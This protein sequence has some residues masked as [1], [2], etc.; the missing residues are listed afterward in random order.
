MAFNNKHVPATANGLETNDVIED[1]VIG[2]QSLGARAAYAIYSIL[3]I[4][5]AMY[6]K[7]FTTQR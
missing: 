6:F 3:E 7:I 5:A 2:L 1:D 4:T